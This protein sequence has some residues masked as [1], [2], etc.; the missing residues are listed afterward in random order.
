M[1]KSIFEATTDNIGWPN[2]KKFIPVK[3]QGDSNSFDTVE[4]EYDNQIAP[5]P[6]N[7]KEERIKLKSCISNKKNWLPITIYR[8]K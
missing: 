6:T 4:F 2:K 1:C 5:S 7:V 8:I 3:I